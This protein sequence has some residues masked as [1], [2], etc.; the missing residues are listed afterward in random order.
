[1]FELSRRPLSRIFFLYGLK[2]ECLED[3]KFKVWETPF[4]DCKGRK[5]LI[6]AKALSVIVG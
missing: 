6:K 4:V 5:I 3:L 2:F 1:M